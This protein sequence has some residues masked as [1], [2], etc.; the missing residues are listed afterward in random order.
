MPSILS[1]RTLTEQQQHTTTTTSLK[2][3]QVK[4]AHPPK[5]TLPFL[6]PPLPPPPPSSSSFLLMNGVAVLLLLLALCLCSVGSEA[7]HSKG[8]TTQC[9]NLQGFWGVRECVCV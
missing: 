3:S 8:A 9:E 6:S 5:P 2:L 4:S 7:L 1:V